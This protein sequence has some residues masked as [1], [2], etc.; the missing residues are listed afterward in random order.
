VS[1][2]FVVAAL[3]ALTLIACAAAAFF[4]YRASSAARKLRS[5]TSLQGE[6]VEIRDYL[7][8]VDAWMKRNHQR[9]VMRDRRASAN[10]QNESSKAA[11]GPAETNKDELRRRAGLV[12]GQPARH[13]EM[14]S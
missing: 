14:N 4:S 2:Q 7:S 1:V 9:E 10:E 3:T 13:R 11:S 12:A 6:L 5:M 8:K